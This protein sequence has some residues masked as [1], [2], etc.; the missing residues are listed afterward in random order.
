MGDAMT[1]KLTD[2][3]REL[4]EALKEAKGHLEYCGYGDAWEREC[5]LDCDDPLDQKIANAISKA[6]A[7]NG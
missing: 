7:R 6:E 4:L 1:D 5:A 3:E 2:L